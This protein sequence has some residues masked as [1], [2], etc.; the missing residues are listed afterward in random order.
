MNTYTSLEALLHDAFWADED[1]PELH[2]IENLLEEPA[3]EIG[4]GSGRLLLPLLQK[5]CRIEGL[6]N[7]EDMLALC[8]QSASDCGLEPVLHHGDMS[9]FA[10]GKTYASLFV[11]AF[12]FQLAEDPAATLAHFQKLLQPAGLLYLTV[13]IPMA[14][15]H[16]ELPENEW[17]LDHETS[18]PDGRRASV[19]TRHQIDRKARIL[20]REHHYSLTD[21][22]GTQEHFSEQTVRWFTPRQLQR[23][24]TDAGFSVE[25]AVADFDEELPVD[26]DSQILTLVARSFVES[27]E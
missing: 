21:P 27:V 26:E 13:F 16:R 2:W 10:P 12:T 7:S 22:T 14:E 18:L 15:I 4:C 17:Y 11:P 20:R 6:D 23:L 9:R 3:L 24:L 25:N 8:R 19:H 1:T 5:G